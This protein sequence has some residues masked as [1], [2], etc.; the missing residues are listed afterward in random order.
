MAEVLLFHHAHGLTTGIQAFA[1]ALRDA[2]HVVYTPDLYEGHVFSDLDEGVAHAESVGMQTLIARGHDAAEV[3]SRQLVYA[4]FSL[5][6]MPAQSLAETRPGARGALLIHSFAPVETFAPIWPD[7]VALQVH[8]SE[9]DP[10]DDVSIAQ[11]LVDAVPGAELFV[12]PGDRH[13]FAEPESSDYTE[14]AAA[15]L[16]ERTL[17]FLE[18]IG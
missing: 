17:T 13:L 1:E 8:A 14:V 15:L 9:H 5:G 4:G 2:G 7:G 10:W 6:A 18:R 3:L 12:Y 16:L 11:S